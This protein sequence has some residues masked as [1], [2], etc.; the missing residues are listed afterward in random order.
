[1]IYNHGHM[2]LV[3]ALLKREQVTWEIDVVDLELCQIACI[4]KADHLFCDAVLVYIEDR[5]PPSRNSCYTEI[6]LAECCYAET[7]TLPEV[8]PN[9]KWR[10][11]T[12]PSDSLIVIPAAPRLRKY[13]NLP[14]TGREG[15]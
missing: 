9:A 3:R 15:G 1:M 4:M 11:K 8:E 2:N 12:G 5:T 14:R 13:L 7:Q 10:S 6:V